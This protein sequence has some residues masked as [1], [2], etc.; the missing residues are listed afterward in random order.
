MTTTA[1]TARSATLTAS[2][3]GEWVAPATDATI[4]VIDSGTE[5]LFFRVAEAKRR[6]WTGAAARDAFDHGPWRG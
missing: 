4:A 5:E 1:A 2:T 3:S 6:T